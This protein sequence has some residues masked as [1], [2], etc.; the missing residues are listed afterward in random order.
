M[1]LQEIVYNWSRLCV[2]RALYKLGICTPAAPPRPLLD[3]RFPVSGTWIPDSLSW[4]SDSKVVDCGFHKR[5]IP[6][7]MGRYDPGADLGE[8]CRECEKDPP[9][10]RAPPRWPA[11][12]QYNGIRQKKSLCG[13]LVLKSNMKR[14]WRTYVKRRKNGS[15]LEV[16]PLRFLL[17]L[18]IAVHPPRSA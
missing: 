5:K 17:R 15:F 16:R 4:N 2:S 10:P 7:Y 3:S 9:P 8:V 11:P 13:L 12:F 6:D 14:A 18:R 1:Q